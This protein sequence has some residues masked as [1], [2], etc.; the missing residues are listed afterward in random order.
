MRP[1]EKT[2]QQIWA[3]IPHMTVCIWHP[4]ED[5]AIEYATD[6]IGKLGLMVGQLQEERRQKQIEQMKPS[7][8][9]GLLRL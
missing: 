6:M 2:W 3:L 1:S 4:L 8:G 5:D 7:G 9:K